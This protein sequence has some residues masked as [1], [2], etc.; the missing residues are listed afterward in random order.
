ML[1]RYLLTPGPFEVPPDVLLE[2]ARPVFHHRTPQFMEMLA[3]VTESLR[4]VFQTKNDVFVFASSGTGAMEAAVA[5]MLAPGERALVVRGGKFGERWAEICEAFGIHVVPI[6]VEWGDSVDPGLIKQHLA[7]DKAIAAVLATQCET[8][9]GA[10]TD[11][12]ALGEIV[13]NHSAILVVDGISSVGA[14]EMQTDGW[15]VDCLAVG[16]QKALMLPPGLGFLSVSQK[17]WDKMAKLSRRHAYYFDLR[18]ARKAAADS[19]TPYTPA[20]SMVRGL[21][22][23]LEMILSEGVGNCWRRHGILAEAARAAAKAMGMKLYT[24]HPADSLTVIELP[25]AVAGEKLVKKMRDEY[26][27]TIAGGQSQLKGKICRIAHMGYVGIF[28]IITAIAGLEVVLHEMGWKV[29]LGS[30]TSAAEEVFLRHRLAALKP[31]GKGA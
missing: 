4:E 27:V 5:N 24:K 3:K 18:A 14:V 15:S 7:K 22:K 19:D 1:K 13:R 16:S 11:V 25:E 8:S 10:L 26:G 29:Q 21:A 12:K 30:G 9:T 20:I 28:D 31:S 17:A 6:D 2:M 23:A